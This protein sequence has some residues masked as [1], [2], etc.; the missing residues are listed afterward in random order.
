[1]KIK[2]SVLGIG[3]ILGIIL[4][5][6]VQVFAAPTIE[7]IQAYINRDMTF[8][9]NGK[10]VVLDPEYQVLVYNDRSYVPVK[11][12]AENLGATVDWNNDTKVIS[13]TP[14]RAA[15]TPDPVAPGISQKPADS[16][17][18]KK[19]P[20]YKENVDYK[21]T[22]TMFS[23]DEYGYKLNMTLENKSDIPI[24]LDQ[25]KTLVEVD[26][27]KYDMSDATI[28]HMDTRWYR[29]LAKEEKTEGY[30]RLSNRLNNPQKMHLE[31]KILSNGS[32]GKVSDDTMV[33]DLDFSDQK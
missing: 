5:M 6:S 31:F 19:L 32:N 7:K 12:V 22:V 11:F 18:Y 29:D 8:T 3:M 20:Q 14:T 30:V 26:G 16:K 10:A 17:E 4:T 33:F 25:M 2:K 23:R 13:I 28:T 27:Q 9:F 24:Q 21:M 1:M 15:I